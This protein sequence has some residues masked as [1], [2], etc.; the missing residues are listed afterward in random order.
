[1]PLT[2]V[3]RVNLIVTE[4]AVIEPTE[5]GLVLKEV[6]PGVTVEQVVA[7]TE[8]KLIIPANVP[9]MAISDEPQQPKRLLIRRGPRLL[10]VECLPDPAS[11]CGQ[12]T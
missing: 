2:S 10:A 4:L 6:A 11:S 8:A 7:A 1:M 12:Q 3:R 5:Q 9:V